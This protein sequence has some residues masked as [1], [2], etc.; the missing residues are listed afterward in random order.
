MILAR[1]SFLSATHLW[2][3]FV[4]IARLPFGEAAENHREASEVWGLAVAADRHLD[5][6][7]ATHQE[8]EGAQV[9]RVDLV[10]FVRIAEGLAQCLVLMAETGARGDA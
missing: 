4:W 3:Y 5:L 1:D 7:H 8:L 10:R 9:A 6:D 2:N